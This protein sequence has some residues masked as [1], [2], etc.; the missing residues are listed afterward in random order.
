MTLVD[1]SGPQVVHSTSLSEG[2]IVGPPV[3]EA[4]DPWSFLSRQDKASALDR[5]LRKVLARGMQDVLSRLWGRRRDGRASLRARVCADA[6][7][8]RHRH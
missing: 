3:T 4:L 2:Y 1:L 5:L 7:S 6:T 8:P